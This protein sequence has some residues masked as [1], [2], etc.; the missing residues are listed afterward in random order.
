M[1]SSTSAGSASRF[2]GSSPAFRTFFGYYVE[3]TEVERFGALREFSD[4]VYP[5]P[6]KISQKDAGAREHDLFESMGLY[7]RGA[8]AV[9]SMSFELKGLAYSPSCLEEFEELSRSLTTPA[10][11][12]SEFASVGLQLSQFPATSSSPCMR[13]GAPSMS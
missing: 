9:N 10:E 4:R 7:I 12:F 5:D 6:A 3:V 1:P 8:E 13:F 2:Q 11:S